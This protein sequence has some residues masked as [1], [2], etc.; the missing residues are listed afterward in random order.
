MGWKLST[1]I[2]NK[3][4]TIDNEKLLQE[5]GFTNLKR[6]EQQPFE[7]ALNPKRN[8]VFIRTYKDNLIICANDLNTNSFDIDESGT[9]KTLKHIFPDS[10]ICSLF[11]NSFINSW[12]YSIIQNGEKIRVRAGNSDVGT[13]IEF[14]E[15]LFEEMPLLN[16][17]KVDEKGQ[18]TYVFEENGESFEESQVGENFVFSISKRYFGEELD[19]SEELLFETYFIGYTYEWLNS[20]ESIANDKKKI[21]AL[22]FSLIVALI[23]AWKIISRFFKD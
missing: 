8:H 3:P 12:G 2:V 13:Y 14:G 19:K 16:N 10:E 20:E 21:K 15:P 9:E 17:S 6:T 1:V 7:I 5:L 22:K 18:R 23:V 11:L 4:G